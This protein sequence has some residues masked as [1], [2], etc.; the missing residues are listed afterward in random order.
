MS[1]PEHAP[2]LISRDYLLLLAYSLILFSFPLIYNR[3][4]TTHETVHCV[5]IREMRTDGDWIIPH[6]GGRPWLERPP[7][8]FWLTLPLVEVFGDTARVYRLAPMLVALPCILLCA[9]MASVWFGRGV[10]LLAG[11]ALATMR[12]FTHYATAPECDM[13]LCGVITTA[14][15]LFV[16]LEFRLRPAGDER[17]FFLG[18][19]PWALAGFFVVLGLANVVKGL[20]FGD[21]LL[22][23]PIAAYLLLGTDRWSLIRR[24]VWLPGWLLFAISASAWALAAWLRYPD[25]VEL[26]KSDYVGRLN[27]GYMREGAWYYPAHLPWVIFPWSL[28]AIV[29][30]FCTRARVIGS[31]R[32]PE[33]FLWCW[34]LAPV[35]FLSIPEGKHH[36][37]LLHVL[38]PWAVL[39][40][41]GAVRLLDYLRALPWLRTPWPILLAV[42]GEI[43]LALLVPRYETAPEFLPAVL[44]LWPI[45]V[46]ATWWAVSREDL[47]RSCIALFAL[48]IVGHWAGH[49]QPVLGEQRYTSDLAFLEEV[50]DKVPAQ[51]PLL[52]LDLKGPLDASWLLYHLEGR[53]SLLHNLTFLREARLGSGEVYLIARG[54]QVQGL[55]EY[56]THERIAHSEASRDQTAADD[57]YGLYRLRYHPQLVREQGPVYI[58][59]MQATGRA[60]GPDLH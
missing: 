11:L 31:G 54:S 3:T 32:T 53:G 16:Y 60:P 39:A 57:G 38:I 23:V 40:A 55:G 18:R 49:L 27:Q 37:Y 56:G 12:E 1:M 48:L 2:G 36:H 24:Y 13:F 25:I 28:A 17:G 9:W 33:R 59:P 4:L 35:V 14:M 20:F 10:G 21:L 58:S 8:P 19:R 29:G 52:V 15:A 42:P 46:F 7:L 22:L 30:L 41:L 6:Y 44:V 43:A 51:A 47:L 5:N 26:W 50:R 45:A 34:A